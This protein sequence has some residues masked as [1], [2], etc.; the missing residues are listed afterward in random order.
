M[1]TIKSIGTIKEEISSNV[2]IEDA[3][4]A[5]YLTLLKI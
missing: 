3:R 4:V 1:D 5:M 2:S